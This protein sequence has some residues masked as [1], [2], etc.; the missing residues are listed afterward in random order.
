MLQIQNLHFEYSPKH[1]LINGVNLQLQQ[2]QLLTILGANGCGKSTL[3]NCIAGLLTPKCGQI[4]LENQPL[5]N[6]TSKQIAQK[7]AYVSQYSPQTYQYKVRDY[8]VLGRAAHLGVFDKPDETDFA[9]VD[10]ALDKLGISHFADKVY[11]QMSGG[12][13]QLVNLAR[14][15]VQQPKLILFDEPT[16]MLDYANV[17]KTLTLIKSLSQL[18]F[19]VV[20]TTHNPDYPMLLHNALPHSCV[21]ILNEQGKLQSG[22]APDILTQEN[23][24]ALYHTDLRVINV[25]ELQR[26]ICAITHLQEKLCYTES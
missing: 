7:I 1:P 19:S 22:S 2:G 5:Y 10:Q 24:T 20:M 17:F 8:V 14:I 11:M 13:K 3:L 26:Q 18:G 9:L 15:L 12:E 23:L 16:S 6:L 25:P 4:L 21:A